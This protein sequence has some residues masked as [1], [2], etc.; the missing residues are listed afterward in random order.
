[1]STSPQTPRSF[2]QSTKDIRLLAQ[3][4]DA[5]FTLPGGFKIGWDGII[6]IIPGIGDMFT[7]GFSFYIIIRAATLGGSPATLMRMGL[8]L[9]IDNIFDWVPV[10]GDLFD[11]YWKANLRNVALL[12][13]NLENH[14]ETSQASKKYLLII[15]GI[16]ILFLS[17]LFLFMLW[18]VVHLITSVGTS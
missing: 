15:A 7:S 8:N 10:F 18:F 4:L 2:L 13:S 9:L 1:M 5:K 6:G 14:Y 17:L 3:A 12:E 16:I 11:I